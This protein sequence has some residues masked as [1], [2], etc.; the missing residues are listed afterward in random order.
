MKKVRNY[1]SLEMASVHAAQSGFEPM[2]LNKFGLKS[3]IAICSS[4][5]MPL[6]SDP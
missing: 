5:V 6:Y 1:K 3:S 2:C 4:S